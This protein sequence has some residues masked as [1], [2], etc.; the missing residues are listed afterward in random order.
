[1]YN[2]REEDNPEELE[3]HKAS[4]GN[5]QQYLTRFKNLQRLNLLNL[6]GDIEPWK[7]CITEMLV[8][9]K[10]LAHL[11]LSIGEDANERAMLDH[12][13]PYSLE[14]YLLFEDVCEG[15][16]RRVSQR[17]LALRTLRLGDGIHFPE[18]EILDGAVNMGTLEDIYIYNGSVSC[19]FIPA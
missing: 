8:Q 15:Y 19:S 9:N 1:M 14:P 16:K 10:S 6:W 5:I 3:V 17:P 13:T 7:K 11:G 4:F 18:A 12:Q 2:L